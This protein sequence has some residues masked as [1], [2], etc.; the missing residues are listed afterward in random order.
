VFTHADLNRNN[1]IVSSRTKDAAPRV[2]AV[3]DWH[4]S[5]W[6]LIEWSG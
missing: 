6:Y 1:I 2:T 4:Q 3:L 5:G